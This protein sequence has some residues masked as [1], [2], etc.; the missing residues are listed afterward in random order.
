[1]INLLLGAP[2]GGKSYEAIAFHVIPTLQ[3]G[4]RVITNLPINVDY[5]HTAFPQIDRSLLEIRK[6]EMVEGKYIEAFSQLAHWVDEW[7]HPE[8]NQGA[9]FI[10]DECHRAL[11]ATASK[12]FEETVP[13][14]V[15]NWFAEHRHAGADVLL[16]TQAPRSVHRFIL[17]RVELTYR[18]VKARFLGKENK[19][20]RKVVQGVRGEVVD[21][22]IRTYDPKYFPFYKSHT[23]SNKAVL[24]AGLRDVRPRH[25]VFQRWGIALIVLPLLFT[26]FKLSFGDSKHKAQGEKRGVPAQAGIRSQPAPSA[27]PGPVQLT[28]AQQQTAAPTPAPTPAATPEPKNH[29]LKGY[30]LHIIGRLAWSNGSSARQYFT[31]SQNGQ[32]MTTLTEADL[33]KAGYS[34]KSLGDCFAEIRYPEVQPFYVRCDAP[35]IG[36]KVAAFQ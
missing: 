15:Q 1:M 12:R 27:S 10:V 17:D 3:A 36:L 18:V 14:E 34:V 28:S 35:R 21:E 22:Q 33:Q 19:Y 31:L 23:H 24:E 16:I 13:R 25:L 6:G 30:G 4:R 32:P 11:P 5:L 29:P 26:V 8:T 2:G 9:L 7:R 20:I